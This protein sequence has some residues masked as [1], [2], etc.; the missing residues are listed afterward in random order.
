MY[1]K[2]NKIKIKITIGKKNVFFL[3]VLHTF[4]DE[5]N[6]NHF[7]KNPDDIDHFKYPM[8]VVLKRPL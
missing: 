8:K 4:F 2:R 5:R 3:L 7:E 1:L 6:I